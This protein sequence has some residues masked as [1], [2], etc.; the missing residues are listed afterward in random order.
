MDF[1]AVFAGCQESHKLGELGDI[2]SF[3]SV[4]NSVVKCFERRIYIFTFFYKYVFLAERYAAKVTFRFS[5][6]I[7]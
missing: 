4:V 3:F 5:S 7:L 1:N 2:F 6:I